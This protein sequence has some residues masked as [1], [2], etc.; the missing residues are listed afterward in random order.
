MVVFGMG[1]PTAAEFY[2]KLTANIGKEKSTEM[3]S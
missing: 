1:A 3:L 2:L